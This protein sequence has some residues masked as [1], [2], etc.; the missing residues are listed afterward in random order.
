MSIHSACLAVADNQE[1]GGN[2]GN[3]P[4]PAFNPLK[5]LLFPSLQMPAGY[6]KVDL[7]AKEIKHFISLLV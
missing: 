6:A 5:T 1:K 4:R 3:P 2:K 7:P